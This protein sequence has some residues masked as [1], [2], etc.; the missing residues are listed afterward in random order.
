MEYFDEES[1]LS[2]SIFKIS[3]SLALVTLPTSTMFSELPAQ[4]L[5]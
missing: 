4:L 3:V 1:K 2:V 5:T